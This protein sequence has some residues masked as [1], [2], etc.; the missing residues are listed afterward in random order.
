VLHLV[1]GFGDV[2]AVSPSFFPSVVLDGHCFLSSSTWSVA[3][4]RADTQ[5]G[6][7]RVELHFWRFLQAIAQGLQHGEH[8]W[9]GLSRSQR[10][11]FGDHALDRHPIE[12][13]GPP[14]LPQNK[15]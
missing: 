1:A 12:T 4:L 6:A 15:H 7:L 14:S 9:V 2:S 3:L 13:L 10:F 5:A 8:G 11:V